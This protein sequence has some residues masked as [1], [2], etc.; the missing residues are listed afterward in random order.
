[1]SR[2]KERATSVEAHSPSGIYIRDECLIFPDHTRVSRITRRI[3]LGLYFHVN[4]F[5]LP[6][7]YH[8]VAVDLVQTG[9]LQKILR[10]DLNGMLKLLSEVAPVIIGENEFAYRHID[11]EDDPN[12]SAWF[13]SFF[14]GT[15]FFGITYPK[16]YHP[17]VKI[18]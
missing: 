17:E 12:A 10:V 3:V 18:Y 7:S 8:A 15:P 2:K 11:F 6:D 4:K 9:D 5:R 13:F 14:G 16:S 1:M